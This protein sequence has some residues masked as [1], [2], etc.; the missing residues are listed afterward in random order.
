MTIC[1]VRIPTYK[2]PKLLSRA[3]NSLLNQNYSNWRALVLDDSPEREGKDIVSSLEDERIIY[4]P[5]PKNLGCSQNLDYAFFSGSYL[6]GTYACVLEDDNYYLPSFI[7]ENIKS[8]EKNSVSIV[9]RNQEVRL[10]KGE[11]SIP[12]GRTTRGQWFS[13]GFYDPKSVR[14]RLLFCEGIS[15]GGLF[16]HTNKII[17]NL[18]IGTQVVDSWHQE[19]FR[20]LSIVEKIYFESNPLCIFTEFYQEKSLKVRN[21]SDFSLDYVTKDRGTQEILKNLI[22]IHGEKIS[23][24]LL[25]LLA[26]Q[27]QEAFLSVD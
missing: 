3:L 15:N 14:A 4:K 9:L 21:Y 7:D 16:W 23:R 8:I 17:S 26:V 24:K 18:Q 11:Y 6:D 19:L 13:D 2:R 5:N 12:T 10:E 25:K 20:T 22:K 1:E 27:A